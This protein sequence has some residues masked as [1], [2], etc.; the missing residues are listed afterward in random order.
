[1]IP[2][3]CTSINVE[4]IFSFPESKGQYSEVWISQGSLSDI[5][6]DYGKKTL[7]EKLGEVTFVDICEKDLKKI[8]LE[9]LQ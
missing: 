1:M 2:Y 5:Y 4:Q 7:A 8:G 9:V 3:E 6:I